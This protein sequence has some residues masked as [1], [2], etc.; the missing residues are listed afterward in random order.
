MLQRRKRHSIV[1]PSMMI[2]YLI[3]TLPNSRG[4]RSVLREEV[5]YLV[6]II[7]LVSCTQQKIMEAVDGSN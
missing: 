7:N 3:L 1:E 4:S 5:E 6:C 2:W